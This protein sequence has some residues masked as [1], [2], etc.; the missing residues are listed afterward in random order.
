MLNAIIWISHCMFINHSTKKRGGKNTK[1]FTWEKIYMW[2]PPYYRC[3]RV[4]EVMAPFLTVTQLFCI[5]WHLF[6][7]IN[8]FTRLIIISEWP[9]H[10]D[11]YNSE[12]YKPVLC[13][14]VKSLY[15]K[16]RRVLS[17]HLT[18]RGHWSNYYRLYKHSYKFWKILYMQQNI[19][20]FEDIKKN[21]RWLIR[22]FYILINIMT[23]MWTHHKSYWCTKRQFMPLLSMYWHNLIY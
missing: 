1:E 2:K 18:S 21:H 12:L 23:Y 15:F 14:D 10:S 19:P 8:W 17:R 7:M 3:Y 4:A 16:S 20:T 11:S 22:S 9:Q 13:R 5:Q 6:L